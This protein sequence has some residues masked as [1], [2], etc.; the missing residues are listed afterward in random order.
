MQALHSSVAK[1]RESSKKAKL[2]IFKQFLSPF[3]PR[4]Q[5]I[6]DNDQ[7]SAIT[8]AGVQNEFFLQ[9]IEGVTLFNEMRSSE[10]RKYLNIESLL[11]RVERSQ[12]RWFGHAS[13]MLQQR[14]PKQTLLAKANGRRS[15]GRPKTR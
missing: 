8:S 14:L 12:L 1:K 5:K 7:K 15:V 2:S 3:S 4:V 9:R 11:L 10:I 13:R 6:F